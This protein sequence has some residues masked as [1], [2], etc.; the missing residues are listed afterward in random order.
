MDKTGFVC[1]IC[2]WTKKCSGCIIKPTDAPDFEEDFIQKC[3]IAI[4]WHSKTLSDG[5][6]PAANEVVEHPSTRKETNEIDDQANY[7]TLDDCLT[8][9]HKSEQLENETTCE[10]CNSPQIHFKRMEMFIPP[11]VLVIQLKRFQLYNNYW[12]KL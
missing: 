2:H 8:K 9:F 4:E 5:Y 10:K 11:P 6:N 1:S 12:R 7:T 3:F